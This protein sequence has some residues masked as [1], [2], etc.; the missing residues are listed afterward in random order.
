MKCF[1]ML[2]MSL[3]PFLTGKTVVWIS[4]IHVYSLL[5][6]F[7]KLLCVFFP[8]STTRNITLNGYFI[9]KDTCVFINQYQVN[10][11][12]WVATNNR[13]HIMISACLCKEGIVSVTFK[14]FFFIDRYLFSAF[15]SRDLWGD[16]DTFRPERFLGSSDILNKELTEKVLIFGM[17]KR[18]C[19]GD[20]FAR[21]EMFV[22][23]TTLLHRL[24]I[25]NVPGQ[26]LDLSTDFGLTMKP[27]P[28]RITISSRF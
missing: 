20:G 2:H 4:Y 7:L 22:F 28:Y 27:R 15:V 6:C 16:P 14:I 8:F 26:E 23:L 9:P 3:S 10:H 5:Y 21:L 17:G 24:R 13:H 18:R 11:D 12:M 19:L 25:E 1:V